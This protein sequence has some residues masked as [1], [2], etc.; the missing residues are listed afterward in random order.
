[1]SLTRRELLSGIAGFALGSA[2]VALAGSVYRDYRRKDRVARQQVAAPAHPPTLDDDGWLLTAEDREEFLAGDDL[3]SSDMLQ[4]RDA[5]DIPGGDYA[6]FRVV[7][8][9]DCVRACEADSQ[10]AAFTF[11]RSSHPL[12]N[13]RRMCWLKG[14]GTAAPVVDLPA[15]VSGRRGNW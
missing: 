11:A 9:G 8:L 2:V 7:G 1:M 12:P 14:A 15:Y 3:M 13:K 10:C 4:I 6:A 5:V